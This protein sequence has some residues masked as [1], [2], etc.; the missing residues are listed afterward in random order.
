MRCQKAAGCGLR[1]TATS[2]ASVAKS[3]SA[4]G[5]CTVSGCQASVRQLI[6]SSMGLVQHAHGNRVQALAHFLYLHLYP[7]A[8]AQLVEC[9]GFT[10]SGES[11]RISEVKLQCLIIVGFHVDLRF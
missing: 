11:G 4:T 7:A 2:L 6:S 3:S 5:K 10:V 1:K 8:L 9:H